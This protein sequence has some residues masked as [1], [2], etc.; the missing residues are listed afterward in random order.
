VAKNASTPAGP[1]SSRKSFGDK[2]F[3]SAA[4]D[5][6]YDMRR[7]SAIGAAEHALRLAVLW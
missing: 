3:Y 7:M 1:N 2:Y 4:A 6:Q 5:F